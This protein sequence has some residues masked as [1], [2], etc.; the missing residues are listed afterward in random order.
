[1]YRLA[2]IPALLC[3]LLL[4]CRDEPE[5][6]EPPPQQPPST[7]RQPDDAERTRPNR[8]LEAAARQLDE[9]RKALPDRRQ[10]KTLAKVMRTATVEALQRTSQDPQ[11]HL[12]A[13]DHALSRGDTDRAIDRFRKATSLSPDCPDAWKSLAV[14]LIAAERHAQAAEVCRRILELRPGDRT[15]RFNLAVAL[16]RKERFGEAERLYRELLL[17]HPDFTPAIYNLG[18]LLQSQR[19]L[20]E[21]AS[22]WRDVIERKPHMPSA[23]T[24]LA[25]VLTDLG[26]YEEAMAAY[27]QAAILEP[28]DPIGWANLAI[29]AEATGS[30]GRSVVAARRARQAA[31]S[32]DAGDASMHATLGD[33]MLRLHR[34]L[35]H[36]EFLADA[37][38]F[39]RASLSQDPDQPEL[40]N[41]VD[42]YGGITAEPA[43]GAGR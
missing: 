23:H 3:I 7:E 33:L 17:D 2:F 24:A 12:S 5:Q 6:P 29:A 10:W 40:R 15:A 32:T 22:H 35:E 41:R 38:A 27:A 30:L 39:W 21:A 25:E 37:V 34:E 26:N 36:P 43:D 4:G 20:S 28:D 31:E 16:S 42:V 14:A 19:R 9:G 13:G 1:M 11:T 8:M 18:S